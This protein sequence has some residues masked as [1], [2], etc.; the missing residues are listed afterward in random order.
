MY[1]E[2]LKTLRR[3]YI[4]LDTN[5]L[6]V[7]HALVNYIA[8][9]KK[10]LQI[11]AGRGQRYLTSLCITNIL[12]GPGQNDESEKLYERKKNIRTTSAVGI[13]LAD[14]VYEGAISS[15]GTVKFTPKNDVYYGGWES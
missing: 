1:Y 3:L 7:I 8:K 6:T 9:R 5:L 11:D 2:R 14:G 10:Y 13:Q 4:N 12:H 15:P